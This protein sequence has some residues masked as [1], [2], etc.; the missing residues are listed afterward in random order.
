MPRRGHAKATLMRL[1]TSDV[2]GTLFRPA[3]C[4]ASAIGQPIDVQD[5]IALRAL[6]FIFIKAPLSS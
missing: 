3:S 4:S 5:E 6:L 2:G 1:E